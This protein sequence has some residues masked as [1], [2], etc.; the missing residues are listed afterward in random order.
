MKCLKC[1]PKLKDFR[2]SFQIKPRVR[3]KKSV[4]LFQRELKQ[5][6][7]LHKYARA[8]CGP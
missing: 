5:N 1:F 3:D 2:C 8:Y 7:G 6:I 4:I